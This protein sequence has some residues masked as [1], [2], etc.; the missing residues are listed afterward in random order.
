MVL[1]IKIFSFSIYFFSPNLTKT[2][3]EFMPNGLTYTYSLIR[4][5]F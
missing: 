2:N 5:Y 3:E 4:V 1:K